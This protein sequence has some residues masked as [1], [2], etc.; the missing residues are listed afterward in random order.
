MYDMEKASN[1]LATQISSFLALDEDSKDVLAYGA[2]TI[3]HTLS[4]IFFVLLLGILFKVPLEALVIS[5]S[6]SILRKYSGGI[7]ASTSNRCIVIGGIVFVGLAI[8][9]KHLVML[10]VSINL[11]LILGSFIIACYIMFK[12]APKDTPNKPITN[13]EIKKKLRKKA[14]KVV[15]VF[16]LISILLMFLYFRGIYIG[17]LYITLS[18]SLGIFWQS[19]TLT[20]IGVLIISNIDNLL[21]KIFY[22]RGGENQ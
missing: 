19:I 7:H 5:F 21:D 10:D 12:N 6:A 13:Q 17:G 22:K 16:G 4:S 8:V 9:V 1:Y 18:I 2:F 20:Y 11:L 14:L 15:Y 3:L